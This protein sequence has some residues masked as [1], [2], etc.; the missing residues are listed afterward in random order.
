MPSMLRLAGRAASSTAEGTGVLWLKRWVM[1][2]SALPV[3]KRKF[4]SLSLERMEISLVVL[5]LR[6]WRFVLGEWYREKTD[7]A[8]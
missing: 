5:L 6:L 4:R 2:N 8:H 7:A 3:S 1:G